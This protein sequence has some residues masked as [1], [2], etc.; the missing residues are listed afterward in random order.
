MADRRRNSQRRSW[1][2]EAESLRGDY[3]WLKE[4]IRDHAW[5]KE[6]VSEETMIG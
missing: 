2:V 4:N 1:L 6:K 5:W 3:D